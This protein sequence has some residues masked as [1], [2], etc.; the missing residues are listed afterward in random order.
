MAHI[1][2]DAMG[3]DFAPEAPIYGA[4]EAA[5][6]DPELRIT[7][8]GT[9][10]ARD[11]FFAAANAPENVDWMIATQVIA[12]DEHN[13]ASA[14]RDLSD[15]SIS[16]ACLMLKNGEADG[17]VSAGNTGALLTAA[18]I[19]AGR[20]KGVKRPALSV[21]LPNQS[22]VPTCLLD[23]GANMDP[24][25]EN[26]V[27]FARMATVYMRLNYGIEKP[28]VALLNVG[29]EEGKGTEM[30][31][32]VYNALKADE[33]INFIGNMEAREAFD[34]RADIVVADAFSGNVLLKGI[35]GTAL[36]IKNYLKA[37]SKNIVT[38]IGAGLMLPVMKKMMKKLDPSY[39][40]GTPFLGVNGTVIKAH[41]NSKS[42][43]FKNAV[44]QCNQVAGTG[45]GAA[46]EDILK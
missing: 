1:L 14:V 18:T 19:L 16:K 34:G 8:L 38:K 13:P 17:V 45:L 39:I 32:L 12:S 46:I 6:A 29:V 2:V 44:L 11:E 4:I 43:A 42:L 40:G 26:M 23:V 30:A 31:K 28:R 24:K 15:S 27:Q 9:E 41:G 21:L 7:L 35:E 22:E 25:E 37:H 3:G 20:I 5:N 36:Y 33:K 10:K